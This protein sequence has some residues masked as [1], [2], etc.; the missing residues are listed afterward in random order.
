MTT[1]TNENIK[2][3]I[4]AIVFLIVGMMIGFVLYTAIVV[5]SKKSINTVY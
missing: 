2:S 4:G 3:I 5:Y 1:R